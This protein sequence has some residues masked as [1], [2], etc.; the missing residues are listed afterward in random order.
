MATGNYGIVRPATV[1]P[2][3]MEIFYT[4]SP[5][6][7]TPPV[8]PLQ[9]LNPSQVITTFNDPVTNGSAVSVFN[10]LY[11]LQLPVA[12]FAAKG[13]YNVIIRPKE[14]RTTISDCGVL[15]AFQDIKG[16]VLDINSLGI[17]NASQL[18]GYRV[19]YFDNNGQRIPNFFRIITSAN[20][21]EALNS[22]LNNTI[23]KSVKY[24][25]NDSS[26]LVFCTLT[27]SS[28]P[29]VRPNQ[30]PDIGSPGQSITIS[31]T[32]FNPILLEIDM[33][34]YDIE[35]LA[36]GLFG[37][38]SKS[39]VDGLYTIYDFQNRIYKQYNL[40]EVQDRFTSEPL[41]EIR[42]LINN[43]DFTKDFNLITTIQPGGQ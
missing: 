23:Q 35:T 21:T 34:E 37:N 26:N 39:I 17:Q 30:F 38:Q 2:S 4:Y 25:F 9:S 18:I 11:N 22:N 16:I 10:G 20:R 14:I 6:R 7:D 41:F 40:Y 15:A 42:E 43:I 3:D 1:S 32:F 8:V 5:S 36:Y 27:P 19:E 24:R 29:S 33:V 13:I 31:N 12:N 28:A